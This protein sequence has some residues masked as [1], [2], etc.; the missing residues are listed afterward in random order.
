MRSRRARPCSRCTPFSWSVRPMERADGAVCKIDSHAL[1]GVHH[2]SPLASTSSESPS[3]GPSS[4]GLPS[5]R[6]GTRC[7]RSVE[8]RTMSVPLSRTCPC[9]TR[10]TRRPRRRSTRRS[11]GGCVSRVVDS[12]RLFECEKVVPSFGPGRDSPAAADLLARATATQVHGLWGFLGDP[13]RVSTVRAD[14]RQD[15]PDG[16]RGESRMVDVQ[17]ARPRAPRGRGGPPSERRV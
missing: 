11:Y 7:R 2:R 15:L 4:R 3:S 8:S 13:P 6:S 14:V 10:S 12:R 17:A 9:S 5:A 16:V 1:T